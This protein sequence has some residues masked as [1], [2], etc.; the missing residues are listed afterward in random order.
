M[1][2]G[3]FLTILSLRFWLLW[4]HGVVNLFWFLDFVN[5]WYLFDRYSRL[6]FLLTPY[7][8]LFFNCD[9]IWFPNF[10][11]QLLITN[12]TCIFYFHLFN[13]FQP[14]SLFTFNNN[15][16]TKPN[17]IHNFHA[18]NFFTNTNF[19]MYNSSL[20]IKISIY[21]YKL[22]LVF[23]DSTT[24]ILMLIIFKINH[25]NNCFVSLF[26]NKI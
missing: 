18:N 10:F 6:I 20:P 26:Y 4:K 23:P 17:S 16:T 21:K 11:N 22:M 5:N 3:I 1:K 8:W 19:N 7:L 25:N 12:Q 2:Q 13:C 9:F 15:Q 24:N 14:I